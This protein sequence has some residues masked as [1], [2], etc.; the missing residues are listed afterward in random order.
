M[1]FSYSEL[2]TV[3]T[4][5]PEKKFDEVLVDLSLV[6]S[7]FDEEIGPV[8]IYNDSNL[9]KDILDNLNLKVFSFV[10]QGSEFGP[11]NFAKMRGIVQV[12]HSEYY[13]S[14]IDILIRKESENKYYDTFVPLVIFLIFPKRHLSD[15][16]R[17]AINLEDF[18]SKKFGEGLSQNSALK[19]L[20]ELIKQI[21]SKIRDSS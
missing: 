12:P 16:A 19:T 7:I 10:M 17:I 11:D 3:A 2:N 20:E 13:T 9:E 4:L 8:I 21:Y 14:A 18:I 5:E 1:S 6:C 15:Y